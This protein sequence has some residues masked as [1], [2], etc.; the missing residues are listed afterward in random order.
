MERLVFFF[1]SAPQAFIVTIYYNFLGPCLWSRIIVIK[2]T[3]RDR[4]MG[5]GTSGTYMVCF[6]VD[7]VDATTSIANFDFMERMRQKFKTPKLI[8]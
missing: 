1:D 7:S 8:E 6:Y 3:K 4:A 5:G 2:N